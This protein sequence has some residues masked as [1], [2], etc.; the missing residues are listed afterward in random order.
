MTALHRRGPDGL[1][2]SEDVEEAECEYGKTER[3]AVGE[4]VG[5][6]GQ[7]ARRVGAHPAWASPLSSRLGRVDGNF[8]PY[9]DED[10]ATT[11]CGR[12]WRRAASSTSMVPV[13]LVWWLAIGS[14]N[15]RGTE[16]RAAR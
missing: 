9:T 12:P 2:R 7:L 1:E 14:A 6:G 3:T 16:G 13:A 4:G 5:L 10:E 11:T 15:D 8:A